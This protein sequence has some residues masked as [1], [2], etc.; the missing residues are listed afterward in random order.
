MHQ[1]EKG[2]WHFTVY[3]FTKIY[4]LSKL[5][6]QT[7]YRCRSLFFYPSTCNCYHTWKYNAHEPF[8]QS[9]TQYITFLMKNYFKTLL[10]LDSTDGTWGSHGFH[11]TAAADTDLCMI[12][13]PEAD[14]PLS[15]CQTNSAETTILLLREWDF[16]VKSIFYGF[17]RVFFT[18]SRNHL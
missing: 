6:I 17:N 9:P 3:R 7:A 11:D 8:T 16:L 15:W 14:C 12:A 5:R 2:I 4:I 10:H 1:Q 13:W 18:L